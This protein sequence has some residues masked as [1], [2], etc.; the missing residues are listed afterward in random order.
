MISIQ[1]VLHVEFTE[2]NDKES[3]NIFAVRYLT[4]GVS[5]M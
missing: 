5:K 4:L 3:L 2:H 1:A